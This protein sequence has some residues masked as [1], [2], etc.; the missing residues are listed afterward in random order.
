[1]R[2][3]VAW[4]AGGGGSVG[5]IGGF[6]G[7]AGG[8]GGGAILG[9]GTAKAKTW[10]TGE[11]QA[12]VHIHHKTSTIL[13][14]NIW[15]SSPGGREECVKVVVGWVVWVGGGGRWEEPQLNP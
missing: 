13:Y 4:V 10:T 2:V 5:S 8:K 14:I 11:Q 12:H 7:A 15:T 6:A 3:G 9:S 1:M